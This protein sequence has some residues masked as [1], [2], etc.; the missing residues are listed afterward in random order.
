[1]PDL[2]DG[3]SRDVRGSKG[4]IYTIKNVDGVY[5][6]TCMAW[7]TQSAPQDRRTCK[8]IRQLRGDA[9]EDRRI[10]AM[11]TPRPAPPPPPP[12]RA[13]PVAVAAMRLPAP[14]DTEAIVTD[15]L[16]AGD[17]LNGL[18]VRLGDGQVLAVTT[19]FSERD[20][21]CLPPVGGIVTLRFQEVTVRGL[22]V[23]PTYAGTRPDDAP[24]LPAPPRPS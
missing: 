10:G 2:W 24:T 22:P 19:G 15:Y 21:F 13:E 9:A 16:I 1:M 14:Q 23:D 5:S 4:D 20:R 12:P 8:H 11:P 17:R 3:E 7:R 18:R 6:C